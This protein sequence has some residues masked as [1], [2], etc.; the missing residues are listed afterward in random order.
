MTIQEQ[1]E[2]LNKTFEKLHSDFIQLDSERRMLDSKYQSIKE[3]IKNKYDQER[4]SYKTQEDEVLKYY[5]IAKDNSNKELVRSGVAP[6]TPDLG[7]LN[8]MIE[9]VNSYSRTDPIAGQIIDLCNAY[10]AYISREVS[11]ISSRENQ[12]MTN[13]DEQKKKEA[14]NLTHKK[15]QVLRDCENY[16]QGEDVKNLVKLFE[17]IHRDYEITNEYFSEWGKSFKRKRMMLFGYSQYQV[18]VPQK[19]SPIL[20]GSL[21][22]HFDENTKMV[23]CP[24]GFTTDSHEEIFVEYTDFNEQQMKKGIQ[25]LIL[26]FLRYFRPHEYKI[27]VLD[28]MHYNA[29]V[30]GPLYV[31]ESDKNGLVDRI[32][33][34]EKELKQRIQI[35]ANYYKNI[36]GKIGTQTVYEFNQTHKSEER[37][38]YRL[39][40]IN[41]V[42]ENFS[43]KQESEMAYVVNNAAKFGI[44]IIRLTRSVDGGSKG[45]DREQKFLAKAAD[46][47]RII[48]DAT[49]NFYVENDVAWMSFKWLDAPSNLPTDFVAKIE[50]AVKPVEIG[51][52]YFKRYKAKLPERSK[53]KRKPISVPFAIN[54]ED[55]VVECSFEN[56]LFAAYMMGASRS[57]KS[58]LLH[59]MIS[60]LIMNYHPDELE[61]WLLDF[62]M[63][64]FKKY[65]NHR[66]PHVKYLLLEK[67]EDLVYD[68]IDRLE[69]MLAERE[70]VFSQNGWQK[71]TDVPP[72]VY[73]PVIFVII[74]EFAQ[75]SQILKETKGTGYGTD[76]TLKLTNLLQKGAA[77]GFKFIFASQTYSDGVEGLTDPARKQ[78][79][80]RFALKNIPS[81]IKDTLALSSNSITPALDNDINTLPPYE[82]LFK[83]RTDNGAIRVDRLRNMYTENDEVDQLVDYISSN[84]KSV[85]S[86]A[87]MDNSIYV[88]KNPILI[89]G[90]EPKTFK[91]QIVHYKKYETPEVL[92]ELDDE[93]VL[94]YPGVPCSF[95]IARPFTLTNSTA[96]NMLIVGGDRENELSI[97]LS[98]LNCYGR[99][100]YPIEIWA[101]EKASI[102]K[103]YKNTVLKKYSVKTDL[104]EICSEI[105][106]VRKSVQSRSYCNRLIVVL[107]YETIMS[108]MELMGDDDFEEET[109]TVNIPVPEDM[110][111]VMERIKACDDLEEKKRILADYNARVAEYQA[112][113]SVSQ[114]TKVGRGIYDARGDVEWIVKRASAYG[115]H[116]VFCFEQAKD[117]VDTKLDTRAFRHKMAFA[118][119]REDSSGIIGNRKANEIELGVCLY[120]NGK[121]MFSMHPHIYYGVPCNGWQVDDNGKVIQRR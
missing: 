63:L 105:D 44:S 95:N 94:I 32:P 15:G 86:V 112:Q 38:P 120:S 56:E 74:D 25:A 33:S 37:I 67:S 34:N 64:E 24:C 59:T 7:R 62:K 54:S 109:P 60:G 47:I 43:S 45:K 26:N 48:S 115:V 68:I 111:Q 22:Y 61:L 46:H 91:S 79:Q 11:K 117:F 9:Q 82:T 72:T 57:G 119:S 21:K 85:D 118:M 27:S 107:G 3:T 90:G 84:M 104:A 19:L 31:F 114:D 110:S 113:S 100:N 78:I 35:L 65:A 17:M 69:D 77:M 51:T 66:P 73:M 39:L 16:I 106:L 103:R 76:Y 23:N 29:D 40:I 2:K 20:K 36:E 50:Q 96:E 18:D 121:E 108:D 52:K 101:N 83:W 41:R 93:D 30:L 70:Y 6:M 4:I 10:V 97:L 88:D 8:T 116:F 53:G 87:S 42:Q 49:G 98:V 81:E 28:Y 5:R 1:L 102:Y 71:L 99:K 14:E 12:E 58:T 89:D 55:K 92:D 13:T 75:M 80:Q